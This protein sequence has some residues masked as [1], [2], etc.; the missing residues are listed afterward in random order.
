MHHKKARMKHKAYKSW[1]T[2]GLKKSMKV[3]DKLYKK[4][5]VTRN[6]VFLDNYELSRHIYRLTYFTL[7]SIVTDVNI[8]LLYVLSCKGIPVLRGA[9]FRS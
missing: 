4:W 2:S 6:Y 3:R 7:V 8:C 1:I 5:L 9:F